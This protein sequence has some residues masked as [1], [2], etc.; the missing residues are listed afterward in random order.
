MPAD[1]VRPDPVAIALNRFGLGARADEAPPGEPRRWL[2]QQLQQPP[3]AVRA[4]AFGTEALT[5]ALLEQQRLLRDAADPA[6]KMAQRQALNQQARAAYQQDVAARVDR[7][8]ASPAPW[9]E[10]W[11]HFWANHFALSCEKPEVRMLA[12]AFEDE[13]IRPHVLGRFEDMLLAAETHGAMLR[14]LDAASSVGPNS[15]AMRK[16]AR[17]RGLN[18]NLARETLELHTLGVRTGYSQADVTELARAMTGWGVPGLQP[19]RGEQALGLG[20]VYRP[21]LH[22]PGERTVLGRRY[23]DAGPDQARQ[24]LHDLSTTPATAQHLCTKIARHFVADDP[25]PALV[26]HLTG[27]WLRSRG[28]LPTVYRALVEHEAAWSAPARKFKTP[29]EWLVSSARALGWR[30]W[31]DKPPAF[32]LLNQLGQP[33]WQPGSPAGYD[34]RAAAWAAPDALVR[35]VEA[36]QQLA[37][38]SG[39]G[40]DA[41]RVAPLVLPGGPGEATA[42]ALRR[43]ESP[44]QA[45]ALMIVS[46]EFLRR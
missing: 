20:T 9:L 11:V 13:A 6:A 24:V 39:A 23:A 18:E 46:P 45:L 32:Q 17:P 31:V 8:L 12:G 25:P 41:R 7:A 21:L 38:R 3:A 26:E 2:L 37:A 35:R 27:T 19:A 44:A 36:A 15:P 30:Q 28:D 5:Q 33:V 4:P 29:W 16:S 1:A 10:R 43:A 34:D 40:E 22:E 14:Y 42:Q